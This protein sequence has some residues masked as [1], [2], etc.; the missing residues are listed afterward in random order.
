[1]IDEAEDWCHAIKWQT[2]NYTFFP[3]TWCWV[4]DGERVWL[5]KYD[6]MSAGNWTN[7]DTWE[8]FSREVKYFI[9][10]ETPQKPQ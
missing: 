2:G 8:D 3:G 7:E 4:S 5:A 9:P 10:L 6:P 1:M